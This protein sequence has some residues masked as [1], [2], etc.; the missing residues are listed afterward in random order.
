MR[1]RYTCVCRALHLVGAVAFVVL[2]TACDA[3]QTSRTPYPV[4]RVDIACDYMGMNGPFACN[5]VILRADN[6]D[7]WMAGSYTVDSKTDSP[8]ARLVQR[9]PAQRVAR[10]LQAMRS[11]ALSRQQGLSALQAD[12]YQVGTLKKMRDFGEAEGLRWPVAPPDEYAALGT[13]LDR[14]YRGLRWTDD[15]PSISVRVKTSEELLSVYSQ[16]Q[17]GMML[18]WEDHGGE[19]WNP[20]I[21]QVLATLL[22]PDSHIAVRVSSRCMS[23]QLMGV[24]YREARVLSPCSDVF[25][26]RD[27][28]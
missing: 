15:Y 4:E 1:T 12:L 3:A 26:S 20:E 16:S 19:R 28:Q 2:L 23:G 6:G 7:Y 22:P 10:L 14:Y 18:P 25:V 24:V 27:R 13:W 11:P 17:R 5:F 9:V 8:E 21:P